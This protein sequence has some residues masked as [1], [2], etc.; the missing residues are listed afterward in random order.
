MAT[1]S[2]LK[3]LGLSSASDGILEQKEGKC[4]FQKLSEK[5]SCGTKMT[6]KGQKRLF[7]EK[8]DGGEV[9]S[10]TSQKA[11]CRSHTVLQKA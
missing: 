3:I 7:E 9:G 2:N 10:L 5:S 6:K 1:E 4:T 11:I 8:K